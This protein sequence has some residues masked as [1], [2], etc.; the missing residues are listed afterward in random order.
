MEIQQLEYFI[1]AARYQHMTKA[2]KTLHIAQPALSQSIKRLEEE[3]GV[4]LFLRKGR[5]VILSREGE[6]LYEELT[7]ILK[8]IYGL[9]GKISS[10]AEEEARTINISILT[11][12]VLVTDL[13][14]AYKA[15]FPNTIFR[16]SQIP[17]NN[18]NWD[19]KIS[20]EATEKQEASEHVVLTEPLKIAVPTDS[21]YGSLTSIE[22][23][24]L[25]D[26]TFITMDSAKSFTAICNNYCYSAGFRP[27]VDFESD[28][29]STVRK[30]IEAGLG[31]AFWPSYSW[32]S[33]HSSK[34][35]ILD[36]KSPHCVRHIYIS[37]KNMYSYDK[38]SE[39]YQYLLNSFNRCQNV[40]E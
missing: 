5:N 21:V 12:S 38:K 6:K 30:L 22:L 28:S 18:E 13:V 40:I 25:S 27:K 39:F 31:V 34:A 37:K 24:D 3:L 32:G 8:S 15:Q 36:I 33:I 14:I 16:L 19:I 7:P 29:P 11:A 2:A 23:K 10:A 1:T 26:A 35:K 17:G 9:P 20:S 4:K